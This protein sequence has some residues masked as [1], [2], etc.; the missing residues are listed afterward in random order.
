MFAVNAPR[1]NTHKIYL[2]KIYSIGQIVFVFV[3][4]GVSYTWCNIGVG[5]ISIQIFDVPMPHIHIMFFF[6][7]PFLLIRF[8]SL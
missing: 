5:F 6:F 4:G 2:N 8:S 1:V 7:F 3:Y